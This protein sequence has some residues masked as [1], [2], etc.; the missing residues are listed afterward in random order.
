MGC[1]LLMI[2]LA[3]CAG[4]SPVGYRLS[5]D[6]PAPDPL[7][8]AAFGVAADDR[9]ADVA[10]LRVNDDMRQ[11]L[12][13]HVS[14]G[15]SDQQKVRRILE[16]ILSDGLQLSYDNFKT[17]T[18]EE[19]F[20][21]RE[22]N[23][24]SFTNLFV[25][26]AREA[27]VDVYYQEVEVPPTWAA[28]GETWF[29]N[30][31]INAI[32]DLPASLHVVDFNLAAY[33]PDF[34]SWKLDDTAALARYHNNMGVHWMSEGDYAQA[35]L[36]FREALA[37]RPDVGYFWTNLGT[38]HRR[39]G[40]PA[41]AEA[42]YFRAID[43]SKDPA[44][45]SNLSRLYADAGETELA[46]RYAAQVRTFRR[47]NPYY[48][49]HQAEQAYAR[50]DYAEAEGLLDMAIGRN[51]HEH[52]FFRLRGIVQLSQG[53]PGPARE[54]F[55]KAAELAEGED[56]EHYNRKLDVLAASAKAGA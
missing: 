18:A 6:G 55:L 5:P 10:L 40:E 33:S 3:A 35:F 27:D 43:V 19:A 8:G 38:L 45:M 52:A 4:T 42:A 7:D 51:S 47:Q 41:A 13:A 29:D 54:S 16:A 26:L 37:L 20:Y 24:M 9:V 25:A 48:L 34:H 56:L 21:A 11:F 53:R 22:G 14:P 15:L 32:V 12:A 1:A 2:L 17:L 36:H 28:Q 44:A 46:E 30:R 50:H 49:Y 31:H 39:Q 23:C